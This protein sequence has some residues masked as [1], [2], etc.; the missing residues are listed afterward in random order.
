MIIHVKNKNTLIID[1]YYEVY[2]TQNN[3]CIIAVPFEF[4]DDD[5]DKDQYLQQLQDIL[6]EYK[7]IETSH[8]LVKK[9]NKHIKKL[10]LK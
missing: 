6:T 4:T 10:Q 2:N 1:D 3:N 5:S 8:K 7:D 9:T